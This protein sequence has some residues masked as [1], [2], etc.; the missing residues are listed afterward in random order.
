MFSQNLA[1][2]EKRLMEMFNQEVYIINKL[3]KKLNLR[4]I[5]MIDENIPTEKQ[6]S[7]YLIALERRL[8]DIIFWGIESSGLRNLNVD[9]YE[10]T[11]ESAGNVLKYFMYKKF[12]FKNVSNRTNQNE[13]N[14]AQEHIVAAGVKG[15]LDDILEAWS[16]FDTH[17]EIKKS[18]VEVAVKGNEA[19]GKHLSQLS[20]RDIRTAKIGRVIM[21]DHMLNYKYSLTKVLPPIAYISSNERLATEFLE[22][23]LSGLNLDTVF[24]GFSINEVIRAYA[25]LECEAQKYLRNKRKSSVLKGTIVLNDLV[26]SKTKY[27]WIKMFINGGIRKKSAEKIIDFFTFKGDGTS[28]DLFDCPFIKID[29]DYVIIPMVSLF[30]DAS[31]STLSNFN[32]KG[33]NISIKGMTYEKVIRNKIN[34]VGIKCISKKEPDGECEVIFA[35]DN[36][37]FF[38]ELKNRPHPTTYRKYREILDEIEEAC[39]Q[40]EQNVEYFSKPN[41]LNKIKDEVGLKEIEKFIK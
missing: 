12:P 39:G 26:I 21:E 37:L 23:Y 19:F 40:L 29:N 13:L 35:I 18:N 1:V 8:E 25:I 2:E 34:S 22:E 24:N 28:K 31:R 38:V 27:K 30:T 32:S 6:V 3:Y 33:V 11:I 17:I 20:M 15:V 41:R 36:D 7:S 10:R 16:Y 4:Y 5:N 14:V 9:A